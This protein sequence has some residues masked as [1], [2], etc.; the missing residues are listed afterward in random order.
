MCRLKTVRLAPIVHRPR[1]RQLLA[2]RP[3]LIAGR[4][5][6]DAEAMDELADEAAEEEEDEDED[7]K[8]S[9]STGLKSSKANPICACV[10]S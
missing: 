5:T 1:W 4:C 6:G 2:G 8:L 3:L 10:F 7:G 9:P